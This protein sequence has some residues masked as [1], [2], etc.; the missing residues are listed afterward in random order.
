MRRRH[1]SSVTGLR[2][3][4]K[5][6]CQFGFVTT[7]LFYVNSLTFVVLFPVMAVRGMLCAETVVY[8]K[9]QAAV[10]QV[11]DRINAVLRSEHLQIIQPLIEK[12]V[13][14][15][16]GQHNKEL[17]SFEISYLQ[18]Y[19]PVSINVSYA[20]CKALCYINILTI[21]CNRRNKGL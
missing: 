10:A 5:L 15:E 16:A 19:Q 9:R 2:F 4:N 11:S 18:K 13:A 8:F 1:I 12:V 6:I 7:T 20:H 21:Y 3:H 14:Q 17:K